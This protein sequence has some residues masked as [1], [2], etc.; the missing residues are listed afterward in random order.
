LRFVLDGE[1]IA[2][3]ETG[4]PQFYDFLRRT[5]APAYG[6]F[7]IPWLDVADRRSLPL[8]ERRKRLQA[9]LSAKSPIITEALF[10]TGRGCELFDLMC[11]NDLEG[12]VA[13]RL[14]DPYE[15]RGLDGSRSR[16]ATILRRIQRAHGNAQRIRW[17][18]GDTSYTGPPMTLGNAASAGV[19]LIV[20]CGGC[21]HRVEPDSTQPAQRYGIDMPVPEWHERLVCS[22]CGSRNVDMVVTGTER[23]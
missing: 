6:A 7:D 16:T 3:G 5:R 22:A 13:K 8:D 21:G 20:W 19:R 4:R 18:V 23:R 14:D 11:A 10:V 1:M 9:I 15:P 2:G 17:A 12:I